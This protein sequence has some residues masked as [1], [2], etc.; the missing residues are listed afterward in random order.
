MS[1]GYNEISEIIQML[2]KANP[3]TVTNLHT[4]LKLL[5]ENTT[6]TNSTIR[7]H[8]KDIPHITSHIGLGFNDIILKTNITSSVK[9]DH[10]RT[11]LILVLDTQ[12]VVYGGSLNY[13]YNLT[14]QVF[15]P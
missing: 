2:L 1:G 11:N 3:H 4:Y 10:F 13:K 14:P 12:T 9:P 6:L 8:R 7:G 5:T 15:P